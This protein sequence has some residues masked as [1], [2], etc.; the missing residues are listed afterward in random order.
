[1][2]IDTALD[3]TVE[4][5]PVDTAQSTQLPKTLSLAGVPPG[6]LLLVNHSDKPVTAAVL[7]WS[8]TNQS[9]SVQTKRLNCDG[10]GLTPVDPIV[11][12]NGMSLITPYG[13][14]R[15]ETIN[16]AEK[17]RLLNSPFGPQQAISPDFSAPIHLE[18]DSL[19]FEDG[20]VLGMNKHQYPLEIQQRY[21]ALQSV[22]ANIDSSQAAGE[23]LKKFAE[24]ARK[25]L[26]EAPPGQ[27]DRRSSLKAKFYSQLER[28]PNVDG[29]LRF[30]QNLP[31]PQAFYH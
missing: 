29:T 3:P 14:G 15:E 10:Y 9:G 17:S 1:M 20:R 12:A 24:S 19:I 4:I 5:I 31:V 21:A 8:F 23:S 16:S 18:I 25:S 13:Y 28:S 26:E 27:S 22:L 30:L 7:I 11:R 2:I 6:S